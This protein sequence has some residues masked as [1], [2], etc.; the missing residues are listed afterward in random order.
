[1]EIKR[2]CVV[3]IT[4]GAIQV[5]FKNPSLCSIERLNNKSYIYIYI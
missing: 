4:N 1:M 2:V 3:C 5:S